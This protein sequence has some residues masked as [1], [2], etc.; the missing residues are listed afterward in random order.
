MTL[1][2]GNTETP[3][4]PLEL[5]PDDPLV[6]VKQPRNWS[7]HINLQIFVLAVFE[8]GV[9]VGAGCTTANALL[10]ASREEEC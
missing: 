4:S 10:D 2:R 6:L 1:S 5:N 7:I 3:T 9:G 8:S